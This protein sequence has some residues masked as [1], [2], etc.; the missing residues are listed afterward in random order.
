MISPVT[1]VSTATSHMT[2]CDS[3]FVKIKVAATTPPVLV[4]QDR[5]CSTFGTIKYIKL[6]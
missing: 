2:Q 6:Q 3:D 1:I 4:E 5:V